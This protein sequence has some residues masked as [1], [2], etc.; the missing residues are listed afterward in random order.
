M[1]L[2]NTYM[3]IEK[4]QS[5]DG[6]HINLPRT[7]LKRSQ[8]SMNI[9]S[10][11]SLKQKNI[12]CLDIDSLSCLLIRYWNVDLWKELFTKLLNRETCEDDT[13]TL[14][15]LRKSMEEYI[16]SDPKLMKKLNELLA[17]QRV[18]LCSS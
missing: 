16:C 8:K 12:Y 1:M 13:E 2:H 5:L 4:K 11:L 18:S 15:N 3:E 17:K 9:A 7:S 14:R 10:S 6:G